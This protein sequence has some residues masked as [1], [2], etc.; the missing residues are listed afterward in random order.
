MVS[1]FASV[2]DMNATSDAEKNAER[3][4]R[5]TR[6]MSSIVIGV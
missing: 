3:A 6:I 2:S 5:R 1:I 4:R